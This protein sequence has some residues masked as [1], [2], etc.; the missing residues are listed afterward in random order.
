MNP[1]VH[2]VES[3]SPEDLLDNRTEGKMICDFF[4][5][6]QIPYFYSLA[7]N[8]ATFE[9]S[10][11][12]R[13]IQATEKYNTLPIL[14]FSM[15]GDNDGIFLTNKEK[16][17]WQDL[18][19]YIQP[20][21]NIFEG[22]LMI[23]MSSCF[24]GNAFQ[25]AMDQGLNKPFGYL[26]GNMEKVSWKD[27]SIGFATFY[28]RLFGRANIDDAFNAM[29]CASGNSSFKKWSG[30]HIKENYIELLQQ[31]KIVNSIRETLRGG[32]FQ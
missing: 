12:N 3:P 9:Q 27:A 32:L 20:L 4:D 29:Q 8:L 6:S 31:I 15:H 23:C 2:V 24:G 21:S 28:H 30:Q 17:T 7:T 18:A 13:L 5:L 1:F 22:R 10:L 14:H 26:I 11:T 19:R 25:M 16:L